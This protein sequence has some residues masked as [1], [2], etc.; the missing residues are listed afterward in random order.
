MGLEMK[1]VRKYSEKGEDRET[2]VKSPDCATGRGRVA[3]REK[4]KK[5]R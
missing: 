4:G 5:G 3:A 1:T 2:I